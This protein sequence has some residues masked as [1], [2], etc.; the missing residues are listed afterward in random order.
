MVAAA[1]GLMD[2][3]ASVN[4]MIGVLNVAAQANGYDELTALTQSFTKLNN[5]ILHDLDTA[6]TQISVDQIRPA[7]TK[8]TAYGSGADSTFSMRPSELRSGGN[9]QIT[10]KPAR[11]SPPERSAKAQER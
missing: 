3:A 2:T 9:V 7:A 1:R 4:E 6:A 8:L 11:L 10:L 5:D